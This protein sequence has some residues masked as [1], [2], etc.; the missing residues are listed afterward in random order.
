MASGGAGDG[1]APPSSGAVVLQDVPFHEDLQPLADEAVAKAGARLVVDA[2]AYRSLATGDAAGVSAAVGDASAV[3]ALLTHG[4]PKVGA[5]AVALLPRLRAVANFGVGCDHIDVPACAERGVAVGNTP[6]CLSDCVADLAWAL[7]L[8]VARRVPAAAARLADG[9]TYEHDM[10]WFGTDV[11]GGTLGIVGLGDIGSAIARRAVAF[12]CPVVYHNRR[13]RPEEEERALNA[14]YAATLHELLEVSDF[15]V[16]IC[17][18][19]PETAGMFGEAEFA[20]MKRTAFLI[21]VAR[22]SL[23]QQDALEAALRSGAIAGAALDVTE[24]EPL[25]AEHPLRSAPN[26]LITPHIGSATLATR[27]KML[28][29]CL[30]NLTAGL[31][32]EALPFPKT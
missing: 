13:R 4:H 18:A 27:R 20:A 28:V 11:S 31:A 17:P 19:T 5:E 24:P 10:N 7:L 22:G 2:A 12:G 1:N 26:L 23:V 30:E 25:P 9:A 3:A 8:S 32:G 16:I 29:R 14:T 21:N 15:V 6:G